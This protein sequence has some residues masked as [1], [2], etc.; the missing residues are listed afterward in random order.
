[1]SHSEQ[2]IQKKKFWKNFL[3][4]DPP[5]SSHLE[6]KSKFSK[7]KISDFFFNFNFDDFDFDRFQ[8]SLYALSFPSSLVMDLE[9]VGT[10]IFDFFFDFNFDDFDFFIIIGPPRSGKGTYKFMLVC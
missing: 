6:K 2:E 8:F 1:M 4:S 9:N 5:N 3:P 7:N 10:K